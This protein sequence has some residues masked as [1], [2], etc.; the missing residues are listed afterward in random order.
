MT[1][2][3]R[4]ALCL[5][6]AA[7]IIAEILAFACCAKYF[8][9]Y[10]LPAYVFILFLLLSMAAWGLAAYCIWQMNRALLHDRRQMHAADE[11]YRLVAK[12]WDDV[13][14]EFHIQNN[15][16][17]DST[18]W[19]TIASGDT[20]L[21][22][23]VARKIVHPEDAQ[24]FLDFFCLPQ[25]AGELREVDI[26][27]RTH[28]Q[29]DYEWTQIRGITLADEHGDPEKILGRR[30]NIDRLKR[31]SDALR[32]QAQ[33]DQMT[34]FYNKST[35][36]QLIISALHQDRDMPSA[37]ML[38]DID[39]FKRVNDELGHEE[40]DRVI[41]KT[42]AAISAKF[43]E[44]D[45][46]GRFGGDEY[47]ILLRGSSAMTADTVRHRCEQ[48]QAVFHGFIESTGQDQFRLSCSIGVA[49]CPQDADGFAELFH[50]AD[51][52][53]YCAKNQ[54]RDQFVFYQ[55]FRP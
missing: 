4:I 13:L 35:A 10:G 28:P 43:R 29:G 39:H 7:G 17:R 42:A 21:Q 5:T 6:G 27:I 33:R 37:L 16:I 32:Q 48:I 3:Q 45:I 20:F 47:L 34:G 26:R 30:I 15:S 44:T 19:M 18:D 52:A 14:F 55:D 41:Q 38:I 8:L 9:Q 31:E 51:K 1:H 11:R 2:K 53:L 25:H 22:G 36:Q 50:C 54:G 23:T 40:G 24:K 12:L 46:I 49:M